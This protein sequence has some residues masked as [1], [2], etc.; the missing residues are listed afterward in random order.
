MSA[1]NVV[2]GLGRNSGENANEG[3]DERD[4]HFLLK[5]LFCNK[6]ISICYVS[7]RINMETGKFLR[8]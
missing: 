1:E 5:E 7:D 3:D 8:E 6:I 4:F 2:G